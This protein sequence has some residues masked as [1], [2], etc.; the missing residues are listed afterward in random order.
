AREYQ[1]AL[2]EGENTRLRNSIMHV[3]KM[4]GYVDSRN[5]YIRRSLNSDKRKRIQAEHHQANV[6]LVQKLHST[7]TLYPTIKF[8]SDWKKQQRFKQRICRYPQGWEQ[9][10]EP[11]IKTPRTR[12]SSVSLAPIGPS[13]RTKSIEIEQ[14]A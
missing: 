13:K 10:K 12:T 8:E 7:Q 4:G 9:F 11:G 5:D 14:K 1:D 3:I 6:R 2:I